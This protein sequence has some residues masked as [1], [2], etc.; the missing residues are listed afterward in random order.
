MLPIAG[1][2]RMTVEVKPQEVIPDHGHVMHLF[3]IAMPG[4]ESVWHLHPDL[5]DGGAFAIRLPAMPAGQYQVF[6]DIVDKNGF[7]WTLVE[8]L[9]LPRIA[10][11]A[12]MLGDDS[13]W[14]G[15]PLTPRFSEATV[16]PLPD[17][18]RLVWERGDGPLKAD[19]PAS[20]KF[21]VEAKDG[22]PVPDLEPYMG[23]AAHMIVVRS[24]LS[25]FAHLHPSG[26]V[27][28][29]ALDLAQT[30]LLAPSGAG[31][32]GMAAMVH[33]HAPVPPKFSIP[34]GIPRAGD[35]RILVQIKRSGQVQTAAFDVHV[36]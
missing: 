23:M 25:V 3:L 19:V 36:Q 29:A 11:T 20:F 12:A 31:V 6:A 10:G 5:A 8:N 34:Y 9:K 4:M 2:G 30:G 21:R 1:Q 7:P 26:S 14:E 13:H 27:S 16:A 24:D 32:S 22:S 15:A 35:Y 33:S 17:G 18:A 28:M